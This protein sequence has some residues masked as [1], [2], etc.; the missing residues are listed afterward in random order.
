M[1]CVEPRSCSCSPDSV[2]NNAADW[3]VRTFAAV[4]GGEDDDA[5][6]ETWG[7]AGEGDG[8]G[9]DRLGGGAG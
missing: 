1:A 7:G 6:E 2:S 3:G 9:E 4:G 8:G 5:G